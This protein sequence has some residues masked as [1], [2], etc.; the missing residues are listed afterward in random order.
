MRFVK[1]NVWCNLNCLN[2][3]TTL[4]RPTIEYNLISKLEVLK[5]Q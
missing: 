3:G 5:I 2:E 1:S 4:V